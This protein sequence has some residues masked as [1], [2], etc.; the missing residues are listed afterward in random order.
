MPQKL[1]DYGYIMITVFLT[2][3]GQIILKWR[4]G[5]YGPLPE[6]SWEKLKFLLL[7]LV[8]PFILAGFVAAKA[9]V[10]RLAAPRS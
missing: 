5:S 9:E 10:C 4:I 2:A 6:P 8:D 7:L 1:F 3:F